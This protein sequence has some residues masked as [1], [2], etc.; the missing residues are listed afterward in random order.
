VY[1][2]VMVVRALQVEEMGEEGY[3]EYVRVVV[4]V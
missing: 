2:V 4:T 1:V 3:G